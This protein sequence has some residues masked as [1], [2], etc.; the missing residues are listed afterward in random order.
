MASVF[1]YKKSIITLHAQQTIKASNRSIFLRAFKLNDLKP[2]YKAQF[3]AFRTHSTTAAKSAYYSSKNHISIF[4][5]PRFISNLFILN[6]L[7]GN[8]GV[9]PA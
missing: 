9:K 3:F 7:N 4:A 2:S 8:H 1:F 5:L 6:G